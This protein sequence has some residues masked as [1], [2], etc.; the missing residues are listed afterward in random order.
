M[1]RGNPDDPGQS[2]GCGPH[3]DPVGGIV[4]PLAQGDAL[5]YPALTDPV[6][7]SSIG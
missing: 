5:R 2:A 3:K 1:A 6:A 4:F 7:R